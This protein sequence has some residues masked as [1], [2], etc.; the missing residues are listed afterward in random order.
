LWYRSLE[1]KSKNSIPL[2]VELT[3]NCEAKNLS[4]KEKGRLEEHSIPL[5]KE[6]NKFFLLL[7][8]QEIADRTTS[9]TKTEFAYAYKRG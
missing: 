3:F 7:Q 9:K 4:V 2:I 1:N 8:S 6:T 5:L